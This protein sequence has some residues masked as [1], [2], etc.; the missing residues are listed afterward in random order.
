M[1]RRK[2]IIIVSVV[3]GLIALGIIIPIITIELTKEKYKWDDLDYGYDDNIIDSG[4]YFALMIDTSEYDHM[5]LSIS[6]AMNY[7]VDIYMLDSSNFILFN[8]SLSFSYLNIA[9]DVTGGSHGFGGYDGG[10]EY[11][12]VINNENPT[13]VLFDLEVHILLRLDL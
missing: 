2:I 7:T 10:S 3:I 4:D 8:N 9:D 5:S 12:L 11:Y 13:D 1:E 6:Y